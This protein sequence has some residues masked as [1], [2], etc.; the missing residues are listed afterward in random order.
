MLPKPLYQGKIRRLYPADNDTLIM[1]TGD[2][3]SAFDVVFAQSIAEK[4]VILKEISSAWFDAL[5]QAKL[6][7][8]YDFHSHLLSTQAND[9]PEPYKSLRGSNYNDFLRRSVHIRQTQ[10]IDFECIVRG[11]LTGS[12]YQEYTKG[13]SVSGIPL[14]DRLTN[15]DKLP[16]AIFTPSTKANTGK[17]DENVAYERM[18]MA[19]GKELSEKIRRI[20]LAIYGFAQKKLEPF[21]ILVADTK[22]EFGLY[23]NKLYLIDEALTPD[24]SRY[25]RESEQKNRQTDVPPAGLDKQHIRD[26]VEQLAW[27]KRPPAPKLPVKILEKTKEVYLEIQSIIE[28][29][30]A[31]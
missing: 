5:A 15:G 11:Y 30:L 7:E 28:K 3:I 17:H 2:S 14:P 12:A 1:Y 25:W 18:V 22:F 23:Q 24:S 10:R 20:S 21:A 9:F 6:Y 8:K 19:L 13:K 26:Y 16:Q 4:G 29:A 31:N 27:N